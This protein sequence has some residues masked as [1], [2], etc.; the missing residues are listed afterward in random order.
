MQLSSCS[1]L[2]LLFTLAALATVGQAAPQAG[3]L[4]DVMM[5]SGSDPLLPIDNTGA[6]DATA[7][8]EGIEENTAEDAPID[9]GLPAPDS[10]PLEESIAEVIAPLEDAPRRGKPRTGGRRGRGRNGRNRNGAKALRLRK[11]SS[12]AN[13]RSAITAKDSVASTNT[14]NSDG[15]VIGNLNIPINLLAEIGILSLINTNAGYTRLGKGH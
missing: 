3:G 5:P 6:E 4:L 10:S 12:K 1:S 9:E 11:V 7:L 15:S 2:L 13:A 14:Q 8:D